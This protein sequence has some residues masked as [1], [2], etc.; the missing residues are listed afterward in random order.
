MIT[1]G[2][3]RRWL[4]RRRLENMRAATL[5]LTQP[6]PDGPGVG[7]LTAEMSRLWHDQITQSAAFQRAMQER[8]YGPS[9]APFT[10]QMNTPG[11]TNWVGILTDAPD[12]Q[13]APPPVNAP[14]LCPEC[15]A[16]WKCEH[17]HGSIYPALYQLMR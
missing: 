6:E 17:G 5:P 12:D 14:E 4:H 3:L 2:Q 7:D 16:Y 1:L 11:P 13:A 15:G 9:P 10:L 8:L